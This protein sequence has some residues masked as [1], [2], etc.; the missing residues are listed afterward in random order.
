MRREEIGA[1]KFSVA[2]WVQKRELEAEK[3]EIFIEMRKLS[4]SFPGIDCGESK[5]SQCMNQIWK[6]SRV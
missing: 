3:S 1:K 6:K 2:F 5:E 4:Y